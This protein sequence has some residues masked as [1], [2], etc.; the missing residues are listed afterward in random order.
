MISIVSRPYNDVF[1]SS[2]HSTCVCQR[3]FFYFFERV[4][5]F[6]SILKCFRVF[7]RRKLIELDFLK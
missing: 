1:P 4:N 5:S 3:L 7:F 6:F 2:D